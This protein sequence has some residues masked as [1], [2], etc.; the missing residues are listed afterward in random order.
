MVANA[1]RATDQ[2]RATSARHSKALK[3]TTRPDLR[4]IVVAANTATVFRAT[5]HLTA[6]VLPRKVAPVVTV[7]LAPVRKQTARRT[8]IVRHS[9]VLSGVI[10]TAPRSRTV[11]VV[12]AATSA[13]APVLPDLLREIART[14]NLPL[15]APF[16]TA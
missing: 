4:V 3:G 16:L 6:E 12:T 8:M 1:P 9:R 10:M 13:T 7:L 15:K 11:V 14:M 5:N 2:D